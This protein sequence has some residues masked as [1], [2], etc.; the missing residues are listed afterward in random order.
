MLLSASTL[1]NSRHNKGAKSRK[2][3]H[4]TDSKNHC[5]T[6]MR[7]WL[8]CAHS[9][10]LQQLGSTACLYERTAQTAFDRYHSINKMLM[11]THSGWLTDRKYACTY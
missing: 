9:F 10:W 6:C 4:D 5:V 7:T 1:F 2:K 11:Y 3:Q 8:H